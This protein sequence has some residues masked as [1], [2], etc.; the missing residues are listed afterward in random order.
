ME[1]NFKEFSKEDQLRVENDFLKMKLMLESGAQFGK[2]PDAEL[3]PEVENE[4]LQKIIEFER[5]FGQHKRVKVFDKLERPGH[6]KPVKDLADS[7]IADAWKELSDYLGKYSL[8]LEA[9]SP[10]VSEKELYRFAVEELFEYE[11]DDLNL[12]GWI[13]NFIYDDFHPDLYYDLP[14][15]AEDIIKYII[16]KEPVKF[17]FGFRTEEFR[18][19]QYDNLNEKEGLNII[20]VYKEGFDQLELQLTE[21]LNCDIGEKESLVF[22]KYIAQALVNSEKKELTGGWKINFSFDEELG[23][24][25]ASSVEIEGIDI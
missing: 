1:E 8:R 13:H 14:R 11:M 5:Q 7:E 19:N 12:P 18:I 21:V 20:N 24:W 22:G 16:D 25:Y 17:L 9:C 23:E 2:A 6:F 10:N 3:P 15:S 4:F